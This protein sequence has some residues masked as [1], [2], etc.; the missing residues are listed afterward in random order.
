MFLTSLLALFLSCSTPHRTEPIQ[1]P[2][3]SSGVTSPESH[4]GRPVG[5]DF[6]LVDWKEVSSYFE[7]L[8]GES[9]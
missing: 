8:T 3:E 4:L 2:A 5:A 1:N 6:H 7:K 9:D